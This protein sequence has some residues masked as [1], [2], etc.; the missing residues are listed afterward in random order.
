MHHELAA[1]EGLIAEAI[2]PED[3]PALV[4]HLR[5][6]VFRLDEES[7]IVRPLECGLRRIAWRI[8][9]RTVRLRRVR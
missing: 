5:R 4:D 2:E 1:P 9:G 8:A 6:V 7:L 3:L